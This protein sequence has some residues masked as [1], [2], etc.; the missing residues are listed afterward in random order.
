MITNNQETLRASMVQFIGA[1]L[2]SSPNGEVA[3]GL[4]MEE[5]VKLAMKDEKTFNNEMVKPMIKAV[6]YIL[7]IKHNELVSDTQTA[8]G[9]DRSKWPLPVIQA[10]DSNKDLIEQ[11]NKYIGELI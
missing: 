5:L 10:I 3:M 4:V 9:M 2:S 11:L 1:I 6:A 8:F 7:T